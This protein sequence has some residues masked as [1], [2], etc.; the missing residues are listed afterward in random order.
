MQR[1][2]LMCALAVLAACS[3]LTSSRQISASTGTTM[4]TADA[5]EPL[6][7][8][9]VG[10]WTL[11]GRMG[12]TSLEQDVTAK[13]TLQENYLE[14]H[15]LQSDSSVPPNGTLY[16]AGYLIGYE[17]ATGQYFLHLFD[18][19]GSGFSKTIG[20]GTRQGNSI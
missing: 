14:M 2:L 16:E 5:P 17:P 12:A 11:T 8:H 10:A 18:I 9:L 19:F 15:F 6:L 7:A 4:N 13:W 3:T 20:V 1:L